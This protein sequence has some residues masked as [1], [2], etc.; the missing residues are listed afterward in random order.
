M[1]KLSSYLVAALLLGTV[2]CQESEFTE[3]YPDPAKI[4]KTTIEKQY[5]GFLVSNMDYVLP[6]YRNYFVT[7]R[8]SLNHYNQITGWPNES[9]QYVPGSSG[10]EDVWYNYYNT[11]L[12]FREL[13]NVYAKA[14]AEDQK[15]KAIFLMTAKIYLYDYT[16]R[17]VDLHGDIP[18]TEAGMISAN[19]GDYGNSLPK[20]DSAESIYTLMLDDLKTIATQLNSTTLNAG[21][22]KSFTTQDFINKGDLMTWKRYTNSLRLRMLNR[23]SGAESFKSRATSE[24]GEILGNTTT[25]PIVESNDQNVQVNIYDINTNI[26]S[27]G[28]RD[29]LESGGWYGNTASKAMMD[30]MNMNKDPRL[31]LLF[32]PGE[33][34]GG[35]YIGLDPMATNAVQTSMF[36]AG[37]VA[38]YNRYNLSRNQFFPGVLINAANNS[39]IKAEYYLRGSNDAMAKAA[40]EKGIMQSVEFFNSTIKLSNATGVDAPA[41][42][43]DAQTMA[44]IAMDAI[45]WA[46]AST[47]ADKLSLIANQ[48]WLHY[49]IVQVY[50]GWA[51]IRRLDLPKFSFQVDNAN[52]QTVPPVRWN[53]PGNEVTYNP[54]NYATVRDKDNLNTKLFWD[55]K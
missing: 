44:Y 22:Q 36:N 4:S 15:N 47:S 27:K 28:F 46:K 13:E 8:T 16:Q 54:G 40:Y 11:L 38:I 19:G 21:Y 26:N 20:F 34:A 39:F 24:I 7:L 33:K 2:A 6:Q 29:G 53:Y 43:T 3:R 55:V 41:A 42:A 51:E 50:E 14:S 5:T 35:Q 45:N 31:A 30:H 49:N 32:E 37:V 12:Q 48:K 52:K 9:G 17:I 18:F 10:V 25:Y 1:K 23:V